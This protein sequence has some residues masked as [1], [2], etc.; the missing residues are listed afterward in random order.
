[1]MVVKMVVMW[2]YLLEPLKVELL[3]VCSEYQMVAS[4][5]DM[6]AVLRAVRKAPHLVVPM[7]VLWVRLL[8]GLTVGR[9][10]EHWVAERVGVKVRCWVVDWEF[11]WA[12]HWEP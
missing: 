2:V 3:V 10:D 7:A 4:L 9:S 1:M 12:A 5:V 8:A 11:L 6:L